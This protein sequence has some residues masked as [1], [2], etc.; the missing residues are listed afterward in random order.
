MS[1][2]SKKIPELASAT[3]IS[4]TD[5]LMVEQFGANTST[6]KKVTANTLATYIAAQ[7][8]A[9]SGTKGDKGDVGTAGAK[10]DVGTKGD[11]GEVGTGEPINK[12]VNG[13][14]EVVLDNDGTLILPTGSKLSNIYPGLAIANST[15]FI[16]DDDGGITSPDGAQYIQVNTGNNGIHIGTNWT[17]QETNVKEWRFRNDGDLRLPDGGAIRTSY[18]YIDEDTDISNNALRIGGGNGVVIKTDVDAKTWEFDNAGNITLPANGDILDSNGTTV[19]G[20]NG[21]VERS[22]QF[23]AGEAG[24]TAGTLAL[25]PTDEL[26]FCTTDWFDY[27]EYGGEY[28]GLVTTGEFLPSQTGFVSNAATI[29]RVNVPPE[30][31]Y[32]LQNAVIVPGDWEIAMADPAFGGTHICTD[33]AFDVDNNPVFF[34]LYR[35]GPDPNG[36]PEG[37]VFTVTYNGPVPQPAI[38]QQ[39]PLGISLGNITFNNNVI[40]S[41]SNQVRINTQDLDLWAGTEINL[42]ADNNDLWLTDDGLSFDGG[43]ALM[44]PSYAGVLPEATDVIYTA[45]NM[46]GNTTQAMKLLIKATATIDSIEEYQACEMLVV[47]S[48]NISGDNPKIRHTVYAV[49]HTSDA[50]FATFG[51]RWNAVSNQIEITATN[52]NTVGG[53]MGVEVAALEMTNWD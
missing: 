48:G 52:L 38:W 36:I 7:V 18:G 25:I 5:L 3:S 13:L 17:T 34:W 27:S 21:V 12:L 4:N 28:S 46:R 2:R 26:Y 37:S 19:L 8:G 31:L 16:P 44:R 43:Y 33:V 24:D 29:L 35:N 14:N 53:S 50:V 40:S 9:V 10:G 42:E 41:T 15:W 23:P 20:S 22:I 51:A 32:I 47:R 6:T 39:I 11:K 49:I 1:N 30:I 45:R